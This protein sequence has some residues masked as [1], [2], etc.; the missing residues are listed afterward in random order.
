ADLASHSDKRGGIAIDTDEAE[1]LPAW[2]TQTIA[3]QLVN[4]LYNTVQPDELDQMLAP[5]TDVQQD[6][7]MADFALGLYFETDTTSTQPTLKLRDDIRVLMPDEGQRGLWTDV[8]LALANS[9][10]R[11]IQNRQYRQNLIRY[12]DRMRIVAEGDSWFQYPFL[13]RDIVDYLSGVWSV[14]SVAAAGA[15]LDDYL[16]NSEFLE[17]IAQVKPT[18]FLLSGGGNNL[19]GDG[20]ADLISAQPDPTKTGPERYLTVAFANTLT[21]VGDRYR[22]ILRLV[23]LGYPQVRVLVHGYDYVIPSGSEKLP[24]S[25]SWMGEVLNSRGIHD[26][27]EREL[28]G[29]YL[30]DSFNEQLKTIAAQYSNVTYLDLRGAVRRT[31]RLADYWYDEIHPN[32][33]GFLSI[34]SRFVAEINKSKTGPTTTVTA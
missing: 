11:R 2:S 29:R 18:Y 4:P 15:T 5:P 20:F 9:V 33:K 12:P 22:R 1:P 8:K 14:Y 27:Q 23:H 31:G 21:A 6:D 32:D 34:S 28:I 3:L 17:A 10:A 16:R 24:G 26:Q 30:I 19:L 13:L 7:I 25:T